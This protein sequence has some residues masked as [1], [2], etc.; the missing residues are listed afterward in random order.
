[1][2]TNS[3]SFEVVKVRGATDE[4]AV[5]FI[6]HHG[7][8]EIYAAR[9]LGPQAESRAREYAEWMNSRQCLTSTSISP[10]QVCARE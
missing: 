1:M 4:W 6:N 5:E 2:G 7:D 8:G 10:T 3:M 9:F